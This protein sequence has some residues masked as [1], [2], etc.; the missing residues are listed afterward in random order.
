MNES[1][2]QHSLR[3]ENHKRDKRMAPPRRRDAASTTAAKDPK[4]KDVKGKEAKKGDGKKG[5][6]S[7]DPSDGDFFHFSD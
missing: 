6:E 2:L 3:H 5:S 1:R 4:A 7:A